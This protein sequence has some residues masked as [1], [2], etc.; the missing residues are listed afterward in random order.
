MEPSALSARRSGVPQRSGPEGEKEYPC[1]EVCWTLPIQR[2]SAPIRSANSTRA[3]LNSW[4]GSTF[5][6]RAA[7]WHAVNGS[8]GCCSRL[9]LSL[10]NRRTRPP[11]SRSRAAGP[12]RFRS[13]LALPLWG[14]RTEF[15]CRGFRSLLCLWL[16][17]KAEL[18]RQG[19]SML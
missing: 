9:R 2:F 8:I 19:G 7:I 12:S 1:W 16:S 4:P 6:Q 3:G 15:P 11:L 10:G 14:C 5:T 17:T 13:R 18:L